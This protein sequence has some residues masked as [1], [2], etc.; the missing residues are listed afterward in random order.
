MIKK[1]TVT[2]TKRQMRAIFRR[3]V[4]SAEKMSYLLHD[5]KD[6]KSMSRLFIED[7]ALEYIML[8][9]TDRAFGEKGNN[10][11]NWNKVFKVKN[12]VKK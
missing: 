5:D 10:G 4:F 3:I 8:N 2:L 9:L 11:R 6:N 7:T 12:E 1:P